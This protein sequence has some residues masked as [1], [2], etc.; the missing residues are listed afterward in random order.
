MLAMDTCSS[1]NGV[2]DMEEF[3]TVSLGIFVTEDSDVVTEVADQIHNLTSDYGL[4]QCVAEEI[5][6]SHASS[7]LILVSP[8]AEYNRRCRGHPPN[9]CCLF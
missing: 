9:L 4:P 3:R 6:S 8:H 5:D 7:Q 1:I 2:I